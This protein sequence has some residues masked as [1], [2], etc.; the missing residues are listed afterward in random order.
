MRI[1]TISVEQLKEKQDTNAPL[2]IVMTMH[3]R[4]YEQL[5]IEGSVVFPSMIAARAEIQSISPETLTVLYCT[6]PECQASYQVYQQLS[7]MGVANIVL[8]DGGLQAWL[9]AGYPTAGLEAEQK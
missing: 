5:H 9:A 3:P 2:I 4:A 6:T 7:A 8:L 1:Q